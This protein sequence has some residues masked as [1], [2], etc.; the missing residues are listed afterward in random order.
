MSQIKS[1]PNIHRPNIT[2]DKYKNVPKA[3]MD[4]AEGMEAQFTNHLLTQMRKTAPSVNPE[5]Q[6]TKVYKS[7]LD[8]ERSDMMAKT[9]SG[10]GV[11]D[12]VL[13]QIY[14]T[15][16]RQENN[17]LHDKI[18]MYKNNSHNGQE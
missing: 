2:Q 3:Y 9:S 13:D 12:L 11:K 17:S 8:S 16:M 18:K 15:H 10:I 7:L 5:S 1:L 4:V 14:P 6:A